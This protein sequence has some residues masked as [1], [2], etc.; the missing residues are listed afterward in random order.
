MT[1]A[2]VGRLVSEFKKGSEKLDRCKRKEKESKDA[3]RAIENMAST[4]LEKSI[5][6]VKAAQI[7]EQLKEKNNVEISK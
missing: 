2:L 5:P 7:K 6:I 3:L 4:M 1:P